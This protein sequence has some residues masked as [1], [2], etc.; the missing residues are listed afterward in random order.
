MLS[1]VFETCPETWLP[2]ARSPLQITITA[3]STMTYSTV[4]APCSVIQRP[5]NLEIFLSRFPIT[6]YLSIDRILPN[7]PIVE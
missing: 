7:I 4:P 6:P 5:M 3:S 1:P 2:K